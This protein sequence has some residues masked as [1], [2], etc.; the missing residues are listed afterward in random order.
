MSLTILLRSPDGIV[1]AADS[2][3]TEGY[4]L[5]GPKTKDDS[6]K[7]IRLSDDF[8][9]M[10]HGL[11]DIGTDGIN[12]LKEKVGGS[13]NGISSLAELIGNA[14]KIFAEVNNEW[15]VKNPEVKRRDKDTGFIIGGFDR[16]EAAFKVYNFES[17]EFAPK[18]VA[19]NFFI[20]GQWQIARFLLMKLNGGKKNI[21]SL[22]KLSAVLLTAT[23]SVDKT[24]G[25]PMRIASITASEGFRWVDDEEMKKLADFNASFRR[26]FQET[27]EASLNAVSKN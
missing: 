24:V 26:V 20:A 18:P 3:V 9:V 1:M 2:R 23:A 15:S 11:Y 12:A 17:P 16:R 8:G 25:G 4:T 13:G 21:N 14:K 5:Q 10:T 7:F 19:G 27:L 6:V 22:K